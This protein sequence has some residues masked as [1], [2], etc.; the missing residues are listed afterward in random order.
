MSD[1]PSPLTPISCD[2]R[3]FSFMP[4]LVSRLRRSRSWLL[5]KRQ[6][7]LAFYMVNLWMGA[8]HEVPAAS[9]EDDDDV[10]AD[11]AMCEPRKWLKVKESVLRGWVKCS[12]GRLY[13]PVVAE[14]ALKSS[15]RK[16]GYRE[17][18][19]RARI[20]KSQKAL[21]SDDRSIIDPITEPII[22]PITDLSIV[23][24][25]GTGTGTVRKKEEEPP[26]AAP[27]ISET[28][29]RDGIPIL[30]ALIGKSDAQTR[31][32]L[33]LLRKAAH[34]DCARVYAV[35][36]EAESLRPSNPSA[37]LIKAATP[38]AERNRAPELKFVNGVA[39][40]PWDGT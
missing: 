38:A 35:I 32:F 20:A 31:T 3:D 26:Q 23:A 13:H 10:L 22:E 18:L 27:T 28:L 16:D 6:P 25:R 5:A 11:I 1:L 8:W 39:S 21:Q 30:R 9:L 34:D 17:R 15:E 37:W 12:D 19:H 14:Q 29:Y 40:T 33:G 24:V 7:E 2:L 36:R 4:L